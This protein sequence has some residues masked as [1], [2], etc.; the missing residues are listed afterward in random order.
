VITLNLTINMVNPGINLSPKV[1]LAGPYNAVTGLMSDSLR[2]NHLLPFTEP[3][4]TAPLNFPQISY[5]GGETVTQAILSVTGNNAIV[6]WILLEVRS[7]TNPTQVIATK[8]ALLQRDGDVVSATDGV[9]MVSFPSQNAGNYYVSIKHRNHLGVMTAVPL[10][11]SAVTTVIDF[12]S[13][14]QV[15][16]NPLILN[17]PRKV[18]GTLRLLF[19]GDAN[20]NKSVKYNGYSN[21]KDQVL[22]TVGLASPNN[23]V[24]GYRLEDV[25]M[26]SKVKYN[27]TD[28]DR[29]VILNSVGAG[30]PNTILFQHT[31]N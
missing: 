15:W 8:R 16:V 24:T 1:L 25:N 21:D 12:T 7:A 19:V 30:T 2:E 6:D 11:L 9:S 26:D 4:S 5:T 31:P 20:A 14:D 28:N 3:Y 27:S 17:P 29:T 10:Y 13:S 22:N 18:D 23:I